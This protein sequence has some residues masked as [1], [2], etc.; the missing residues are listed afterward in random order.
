M[1]TRAMNTYNE[2]KKQGLSDEEALKKSFSSAAAGRSYIRDKDKEKAAKKLKRKRSTSK[3]KM[4]VT[5]KLSS[6]SHSPAGRKH[7]RRKK[8]SLYGK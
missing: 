2:L 5:K 6:Q 1:A 4:A 3:V 8:A 7:L